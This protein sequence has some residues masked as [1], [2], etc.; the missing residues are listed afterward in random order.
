MMS[1]MSDMSKCEQF[2]NWSI[3]DHGFDCAARLM[4]LLTVDNEDG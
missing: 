4:E 3:L 1:V 2:P